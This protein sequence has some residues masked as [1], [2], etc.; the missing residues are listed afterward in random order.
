MTRR[1]NL[2]KSLLKPINPSIIIVLGVY[3]ILWGLWVANPFWT[4]FTQAPLYSALALGGEYTW[5]GIVLAAGL[6]ITR[7]AT[8]PSYFNLILGSGVGF[9]TWLT[10]AIFYFVGDW[11]NTGG[12][13]A[14]AFATYCLLVYLNIKVNKTY[15]SARHGREH[16]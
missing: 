6:L 10:V 4:V 9:L 15:F 16:K 1:E 7:G 12:L 14:L 3:T 13:T 2:A 11:A 5:G 8:K